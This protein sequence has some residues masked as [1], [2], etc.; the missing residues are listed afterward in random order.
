MRASFANAYNSTSIAL[1]PK[2][3][4]NAEDTNYGDNKKAKK[5]CYSKMRYSTVT[6]W[7]ATYRQFCYSSMTKPATYSL[8][9]QL[10]TAAK[11]LINASNS[12][13]MKYLQKTFYL[14]GLLADNVI[15]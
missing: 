13:L 6:S 4:K 10:Q 15:V 3:A 14:E 7:L 5:E 1:M 12:Q 9:H 8:M 2:Q 11:I